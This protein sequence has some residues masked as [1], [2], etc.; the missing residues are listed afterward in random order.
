MSKSKPINNNPRPGDIVFT[1]PTRTK[2][3]FKDDY[4]LNQVIAKYHKTGILP[5]MRQDTPL[6]GDFSTPI[7]YQEAQNKIIL[8]DNLFAAL[9]AHIRRRFDD[10]P[11][12]FLDFAQNED[13][14][15]EMIDLGLLD[16]S[17][18]STNAEPTG[19]LAAQSGEGGSHGDVPDDNAG[20]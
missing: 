10:D 8:A 7:D 16:P 14:Q 15:Q 18:L 4:D 11:A 9:P 19:D 2:R 17:S 13:N 20:T 12:E 5:V 6:Y 1:K 3:A